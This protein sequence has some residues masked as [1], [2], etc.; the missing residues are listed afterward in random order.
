MAANLKIIEIGNNNIR[1]IE[2]AKS[3]TFNALLGETCDRYI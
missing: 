3:Q 2:I 1:L